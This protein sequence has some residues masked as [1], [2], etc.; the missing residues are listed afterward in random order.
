MSKRVDLMEKRLKR[1]IKA[2]KEAESLLETKSL[3][4]YRA[5][6]ELLHLNHQL[7]KQ[8]DYRSNQLIQNEL[9]YNTLID[10]M[11]LGLIEVDKQHRILK[12]N[13]SF[14]KL[15]GYSEEEL[16]G[17]DESYQEL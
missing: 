8:V 14:I 5:N 13:R 6:Q 12:A 1:E 11:D 7:E 17:L 15:V 2:R 3:E 10:N 4:L 16:I 9:K